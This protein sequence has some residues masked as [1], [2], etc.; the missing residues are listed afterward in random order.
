MKAI[1]LN[2]AQILTTVAESNPVNND[3]VDRFLQVP[4]RSDALIE[5]LEGSLRRRVPGGTAFDIEIRRTV[6]WSANTRSNPIRMVASFESSG[7][8]AL[9]LKK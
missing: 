4:A 6:Y 7:S 9:L 1:D 8:P 2:L 5:R 3:D